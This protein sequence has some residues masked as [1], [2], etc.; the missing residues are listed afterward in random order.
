MDDPIHVLITLPFT[1]EMVAA[2][3]EVSPRLALHVVVARRVEEVEA[4]AW[5][6]AEVLYTNRLLPTPE[7]APRLK[8]IQF[9][10]AGIDHAINAPIMDKPGLVATTLSGA[11]ASQVAE[12]IVTMLLASGH[13]LPELLSLKQRSEWPR[14]RWERFSP[15]ELRGSTVGIVGYGS[16]GR[17]VA[18]LLQAF[19]AEVLATK[20]DVMHPE[21]PGYTAEGMGD[22][23]GD[24]VRRLYPPQALRG[25]LKECDFVVVIVPLTSETRGLI[26]AQELA[27]MKPTAYLIDNSR[28]GVVDHEA[29]IPALRDGKIAG[30]ALDVYPEEP[31]PAESP[32]WKLPNVIL[33]PH[34][35]G[36]TPY[37]DERAVQLF[38]ENLS[39]YVK[40]QALLNVFDTAKGY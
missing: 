30:A 4:E 36:N 26:G 10:W 31:L 40:G 39:R 2:L 13:H 20:R 35:S 25:M 17:Q 1:D 34:I 22:P 5:K 18:R 6:Q 16:I 15:R 21:D 3:Q 29:L 23:Q 37:Y 12:F 24:L 28:G 38:A 19:G 7:Q 33:S 14:D 27:A 9:H 32:L 8:W 11:A